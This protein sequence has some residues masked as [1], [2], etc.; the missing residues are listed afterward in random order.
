MKMFSGLL[1][2]R[3]L[4]VSATVRDARSTP[5]ECAKSSDFRRK[6]LRWGRL[7]SHHD[8]QSVILFFL[9]SAG[10]RDSH[11]LNFFKVLPHSRSGTRL[12]GRG[13]VSVVGYGAQKNS[14]RGSDPENCS[15]QLHL[16]Q[17]SAPAFVYLP[18]DGGA[19]RCRR[20][21]QGLSLRKERRSESLVPLGLSEKRTVSEIAHV[22]SV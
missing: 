7:W 11:C 15:I 20:T 12:R 17:P 16:G 21:R 2:R 22:C 18:P 19:L 13:G 4:P 3:H 10:D 8:L 5:A 9:T 6:A 14:S 1:L